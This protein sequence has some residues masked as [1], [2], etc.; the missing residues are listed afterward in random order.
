MS[1]SSLQQTNLYN[2]ALFPLSRGAG[3]LAASTYRLSSGNRLARASD[4]VAALSVSTRLQSQVSSLRQALVN[5]AQANSLL[6]VAYGGLG[7]ISDILD[8]LRSLAVQANSGTLTATERSFLDIE[9]G[10]LVDEIDRIAETTNFNG[11]NLLD[12]SISN[13]NDLTTNNAV[14]T[15]ATGQ[16]VLNAVIG[17]GQ[18]VVLNGITLTEGVHFAGGAT[19]NDSANNLATAL[20]TTITN[21]A[22]TSASYLAVGNT[23]Q[24]TARAGGELGRNFRISTTGT[25]NDSAIG[26]TTNIATTVL[27]QGGVDNG[28]SV[29]STRASGTIGDTIVNTQSQTSANVLLNFAANPN[30][31]ETLTI[32]NGNG[33]NITFTFVAGAPVT[34]TQ[35]QIGTTP[36]DTIRNTITTLANYSGTDD[37][38]LQQLETSVSGSIL[39]IRNRLTGNANDLVGAAGNIADTS[40]NILTSAGAFNNGT[41]TG[42]NTTGIANPDFVGS[43]SGFT[44]TFVGANS[45]TLNLTVGGSTYSGAITNTAPGANTTARL[46][47]TGGG[48]FDIELR[49]GSGLAVTNQSDATA[50]AARIDNAFSTLNFTQERFVSSFTGAGALAGGSAFFR[51]E[52]FDSRQIDDVRVVES[53]AGDALIEVSVDGETFRSQTGIGNAV[54]ARQRIELVSTDNGNN[55]LTLVIGSA[56]SSLTTP[57]QAASFEEDLRQSFDADYDGQGEISFTIGDSSDDTIGVRINGA[58]SAR[59]FDNAVPS[60]ATQPDAANAI[61]AID[62]AIARLGEVLAEVGSGQSRLQYTDAN[63]SSRI[64]NVDAARSNL[65]DTDVASE[66]TRYATLLVQ[67]QAGI[68]VLAQAQALSNSLL[69]LLRAGIRG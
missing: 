51:G 27:L 64:I 3:E 58:G 45:L 47:S 20:N 49:G 66:S 17:A 60:I 43:I 19:A 24:I 54:G 48:F 46:T 63:L 42:V 12:G 56:G 22:L 33:G 37:Y 38:V 9:F 7:E 5:S 18:T 34:S 39:T 40:A 31:A 26:S 21:T 36:Q 62:D 50:Y 59:L 69:D 14:A 32:D 67:Q 23:V 15:Q 65:A 8:S 10:N 41:S 68:A 16:L 30:P 57:A 11:I 1:I 13:D 6:Q 4:D 25:A 2:A 28:I 55:S 44:A 53:A 35:I 61:D 29:G 52:N